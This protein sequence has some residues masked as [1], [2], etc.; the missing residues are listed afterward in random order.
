MNEKELTL[1]N[2]ILDKSIEY[3]DFYIDGFMVLKKIN[4]FILKYYQ[5]PKLDQTYVNKIDIDES[6]KISHE[7]LSSIDYKYA[8]YLE[9][10]WSDGKFIISNKKTILGIEVDSATSLF[11]EQTNSRKIL[12]HKNNNIVDA[13]SIVHELIHDFYL[14]EKEEGND[15]FH[16][17]CEVPTILVE[18]LFEDYLKYKGLFLEDIGKNK[19]Q[20]FSIISYKSIEIDFERFILEEYYNNGIV[21]NSVISSYLQNKT[22]HYKIYIDYIIDEIL[23]NNTINID[24]EARNIL[25]VSFASYIHQK[26]L[27]DSNSLNKLNYINENFDNVELEEMFEYLG[28]E[29]KDEETDDLT[30]ESYKKIF[31]SYKREL[32]TLR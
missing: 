22:K 28:F 31:K 16:F 8:Y 30:D 23:K 2:S 19:R 9:K 15:T 32:K 14:K 5:Q 1:F 17:L 26:I 10:I 21:N 24:M 18:F 11:C 6:Y 12:I 4:D 13:F 3:D 29:I 25:G 20:I 27:D 7:F